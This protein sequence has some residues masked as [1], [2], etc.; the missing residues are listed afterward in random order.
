[1]RYPAGDAREG[2]AERCELALQEERRRLAVYARRSSHDHLG[3]PLLSHTFD[4]FRDRELFRSHALERREQLAEHEVASAHRAGALDGEQVVD[5]A[6]DA[7][8]VAVTLRVCA[9]GADGAV[10]RCVNL[11]DVAAQLAGT[12]DVV[13]ARE[14]CAQIARERFARSQQEQDVPLRCLLAH[15]GESRQERDGSFEL[16]REQDA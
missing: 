9:N 14:L 15:A 11:G 6:D 1:M 4:Q 7:E 16:S 8:Q 12:Q 13:Q 5:P 3:D 2:N 10:G